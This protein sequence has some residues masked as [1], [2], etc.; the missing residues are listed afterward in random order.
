[1]RARHSYK[2]NISTK[3]YR[4]NMVSLY[5]AGNLVL[6]KVWEAKNGPWMQALHCIYGTGALIGPLVAIPFLSSESSPISST[7]DNNASLSM[8]NGTIIQ[9][10][11]SNILGSVTTSAVME[12]GRNQTAEDLTEYESQIHWA[13]LIIGLCA[14]LSAILF[15]LVTL[16]CSNLKLTCLMKQQKLLN[17]EGSPNDA[18]EKKD[19]AFRIKLSILLFFFYFCYCILEMN[20]GTYLTAYAVKELGW[21]EQQGASVTSVYWTT[22]TIGRALGIVLIKV[23]EIFLHINK[24]TT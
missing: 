4:S 6:L 14:C 12:N 8:E 16:F 3:L 22:F 2:K 17:N 21:T 11:S 9:Q 24:F 20:I 18:D 19:K 5:A 7:S 1:M 13:Y 15:L 10:E 23:W